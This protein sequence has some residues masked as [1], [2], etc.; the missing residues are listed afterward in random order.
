MMCCSIPISFEQN[1]ILFKLEGGSSS[2]G[3]IQL[4][5]YGVNA[6]V[7]AGNIPPLLTGAT[8]NSTQ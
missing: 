3:I 8:V 1:Y 4:Q 7:Q 6:Q 2:D 5:Q